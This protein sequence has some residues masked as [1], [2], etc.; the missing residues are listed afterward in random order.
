VEFLPK[1][2]RGRFRLLYLAIGIFLLL[3]LV[4][5]GAAY[6][7]S[8]QIAENATTINLAG[9]QRMLSQR[10]VKA[11]LH[12]DQ[13][14]NHQQRAE[15]MAELRLTFTLFD[16][17]LQSL[18]RGGVTIGGDGQPVKIAA[19][20]T[21]PAQALIN[22]AEKIWN[23]YRDQVQELLHDPEVMTKEKIAGAVALANRENLELLELMN[24][25]TT[26]LEESA[27]AKT[28][29]IR[30]LQ[31][32]TFTLAILSFINI[33]LMM[34]KQLRRASRHKDTLN[35]IIHKINAGILVCDEH[36]TIKAAN[37]SAGTLFGYEA[38]SMIGMPRDK[39][40]LLQ[41]NVL[42]GRR[43]DGSLFHAESQYRE[44]ILDNATV[45]LKTV[46]DVSQQRS[47]E[48]TLSHLAYHDALTGLPNRLLFDDRLQQ[49]I[50]SA[51]R[52]GGKLAVLFVD[53]NKFKQVND[54]HGHHVGDLLL[55]EIAMRLRSCLREEDT[56]SRFG[57]DEFGILLT[58]I[59]GQED[60]ALVITHLLETLRAV[61]I[62][63]GITLLPDASV[64][65]SMYPDDG[66]DEK[67]LVRRADEAMYAAKRNSTCHFAFYAAVEDLSRISDT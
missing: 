27:V 5:L 7:L 42:Y 34:R 62:A 43:Q 37:H 38:S 2:D 30:L 21:A 17:T 46:A 59:A 60:C 66:E 53:L 36:G 12:L 61:F 28:S 58:S 15:A 18:H 20:K 51:R 24:S 56:I 29:R 9:R 31:I 23:P 45:R 16:S 10:M 39:L 67:I 13:A 22:R 14:S 40:L 11:L 49:N 4:V 35:N 8:Y 55:K 25:L 19:I 1:N 54:N 26:A 48:K 44:L 41:D 47:L 63:E 65:I 32:A 52:R 57:G 6:W 33:I 64:G 50:L 3:D